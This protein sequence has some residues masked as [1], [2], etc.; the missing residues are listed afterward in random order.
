MYIDDLF[1]SPVGQ[2]AAFSEM[3]LHLYRHDVT[4][5]DYFQPLQLDTHAAAGAG[6]RDQRASSR[7]ITM[8]I[9]AADKISQLRPRRKI[10]TDVLFC[11]VPYFERKTE[12]RLLVR[13]LLGL[14]QTDAKILCLLPV[15]APCR[16]DLDVQLAAAGRSGQVTFIDPLTS[17]NSTEARLLSMVGRMRGRSA[18]E[19]TVQILEP[20][21]L[22]PGREFKT[23]F[24]HRAYFVEAWE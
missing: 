10:K 14:A 19:K 3:Q 1:R 12:N 7:L 8:A 2:M 15:G 11:P 13:M 9:N 23:G 22:S 20:Y 4:L 21:G 24:E 17:S 5:Q 16:D 18:F 6:T